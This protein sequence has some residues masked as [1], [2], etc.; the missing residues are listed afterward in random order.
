MGTFTLYGIY[1]LADLFLNFAA[2]GFVAALLAA[3][4]AF[5]GKAPKLGTVFLAGA[6]VAGVWTVI[7]LLEPAPTGA[8]ETPT[9]Q[10]M[11]LLS[12]NI[13]DG[14]GNGEAKA[15]FIRATEPDVVFLQESRRLSR[16]GL[17]EALS[18]LYPYRATLKPY[19]L[20]I[21]A[22]YPLSR[23][24]PVVDASPGIRGFRVTME[25]ERQAVTLVNVQVT[26]PG[27]FRKFRRRQTEYRQIAQAIRDLEGPVIVA[28]DFNASHF[29]LAF[30]RFLRRAALRSIHPGWWAW[31]TTWPAFLPAFGLQIDHVLFRGPL[32]PLDQRSGPSH[33]SN[34][35]PL[36]VD[37]DLRAL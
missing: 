29:S 17:K 2:H 15:A 1:W 19:S 3:L 31:D 6:C 7:S 30:Q 33:G 9:G 21:Y 34:H 12:F 25:A 14:H 8:S 32:R 28:G 36:V 11:R 13:L 18:A 22:R 5:R 10:R 4:L 37:L 23:P 27:D 24:V 26:R 16:S 20:R 35:R